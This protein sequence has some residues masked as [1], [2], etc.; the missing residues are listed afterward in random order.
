[1]SE[2]ESVELWLHSYKMSALTEALEEQGLSDVDTIMQERLI[3]LYSEIVPFDVQQ[4]IRQRIDSEVEAESQEREAART[5]AVFHVIENGDENYLSTDDPIELLDAAKQLRAYLTKQSGVS[6]Q[7]F[8]QSLAHAT[9]IT[10]ERFEN[11]VRLRMDNTGKVTGAFDIDFDKREFS[12]VN[13][14]DGWKAFSVDDVSTAA[15]HAMRKKNIFN[16]ERWDIL[17]KYLDGKEITSAGH[18]SARHVSFTDEIS[19]VEHLLNF[20]MNADFDVDEMFGTYVCTIEND[21]W[22]NI[23]ANYDMVSEQVCDSLDLALHHGDGSDENFGYILNAA[24]K[25]ILLRKMDD[26]CQSQN[27]MSLQSYAQQY[28]A[29]EPQEFQTPQM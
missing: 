25:E 9:P 12:A 10:K 24:E 20:C 29:E 21:D 5:Y 2:Y 14:M 11:L 16:E 23:Y 8:V 6:T 18:L 28:M 27:G 1:M 17:L 19:E 15:Y 22:I 26:Y 13:V 7:S 3:E 4:E